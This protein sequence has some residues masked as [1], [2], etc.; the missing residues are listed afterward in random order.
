MTVGHAWRRPFECQHVRAD[1]AGLKVSADRAFAHTGGGGGQAIDVADEDMLKPGGFWCVGGRGAQP[2]SSPE[3]GAPVERL[4]RITRTTAHCSGTRKAI[5]DPLLC[6]GP[7]EEDLI[8]ESEF[9]INATPC[10]R[11]RPILRG[12]HFSGYPFS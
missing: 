2:G 3:M 8:E 4:M 9:G 12:C 1:W 7:A 6:G 11:R 10:P 5:D